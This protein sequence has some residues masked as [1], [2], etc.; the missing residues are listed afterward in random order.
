MSISS[1]NIVEIVSN[2][3]QTVNEAEEEDELP[4]NVFVVAQILKIVAVGAVQEPLTAEEDREVY[5]M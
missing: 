5:Q 2:L 3:S 4:I 1:T